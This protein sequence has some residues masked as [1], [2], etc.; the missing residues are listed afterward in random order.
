M[1]SRESVEDIAGVLS[2]YVDGVMIRANAHKDIEDFVANSSVPVVNGLS[3]LYHPCQIMADTLTLLEK[4]GAESVDQLVGKKI[5]YIGDGNNICRSLIL[6]ASLLELE[7]V[8]SCPEGYQPEASLTQNIP[9]ISDPYEA[10][11]NAEFV[12]TDAWTSMGQEDEHKQRMAAFKGYTV[13]MDVLKNASPSCFFMHCMPI[14]RG[15]EVTNE[16][17]KSDFSVV[18]D[19]AENR[20]HAQKAILVKLMGSK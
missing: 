14:H 10:V 7:M 2:R 5:C 9:V 20:L 3:E 15:E 1:G 11:K 13:T 17:L 4:S 19:Q 6:M 8:V 16:V 18:Y 12:Y